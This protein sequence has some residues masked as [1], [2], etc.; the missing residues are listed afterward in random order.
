MSIRAGKLRHRVTIQAFTET[1]DSFGEP[2]KVW[3]A[4]ATIGDNGEVWA[5]VEPQ[6]GREVFDSDQEVANVNTL[7]RTRYH[8]GITPEHRVVWENHTYDIEAVLNQDTR[9]RELHLLCNEVNPGT[10]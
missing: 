6:R 1:Q 2:V 9:N 8:S 4:D 5:A 3:A 7:I 10:A